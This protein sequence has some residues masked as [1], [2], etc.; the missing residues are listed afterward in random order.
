MTAARRPL[1]ILV[2]AA[3]AL[4]MAALAAFGG[5]ASAGAE[6]RARGA[7]AVPAQALA[8]A[9]V[10]ADRDGAAWRSL[11]DLAAR[12]PGGA[13]ALAELD[14]KMDGDDD[15]A[16][17][18]RALG[19]DVSIALLGVSLLGPDGGPSADAVLVATAADGAALERELAAQGF[20]RA[21]EIDGLP[22]WEQGAMAA[23][24]DSGTAVAATSRATLRAALDAR[25][26]EAPALADDPAF[27]ATLADLPD[28]PLAVAYLSPSR[29]APVLAALAA[30]APSMGG[31]DA[32]DVTA[33]AGDLARR[34]EGVRGLGLAVSAEAGGIRIVAAGDADPAALEALGISARDASAPALLERVP[35]DA[36]GF[37][38]FADL[39]PAILAAAD[40]AA[41]ESPQ[42]AQAIEA[43]EAATGLSLRDDIAP[44]LSGPHALIAL[45]G[46]DPR[47]ALL[48]GPAD[49]AAAGVAIARGLRVAKAAV[50]AGAPVE[51][52]EG[53]EGIA[54]TAQP[55]S[56]IIA[57]GNAPGLAAAPAA[58]MADDP[59]FRAVAEAA[60]LPTAVT[61]LAY[62]SGDALRAKA[63]RAAA[64]RGER[65]PEAL[66]AVRGVI[67]WGDAD[68][69]T[70]FIAI[71]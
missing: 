31:E 46:D 66:R 44:A 32:P 16:A 14:A 17:L 45:P 33:A 38:L 11:E 20:A 40:R 47:G 35:A 6:D 68:G 39:G 19:G 70:A 58:S 36:A 26:G 42:G 27:R 8:Y 52:R 13:Q 63:E 10:D 30:A 51:L 43:L 64:K 41:A 57:V 71:D 59:A 56:P 48:L 15:G 23:V 55:G 53:I 65:I 54:V 28:D 61:G 67:A 3:V 60:G 2:V 37:A 29:I 12:V 69:A 25:S 24:V 21:G 7:V 50:P 18:L 4:A 1:A 34:L 49:P 22:V 9:S 62:G 5:S